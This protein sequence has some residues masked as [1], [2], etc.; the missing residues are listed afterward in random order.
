MDV[1]EPRQSLMPLAPARWQQNVTGVQL[2]SLGWGFC[3]PKKGRTCCPCPCRASPCLC[4]EDRWQA[5]R[6]GRSIAHVKTEVEN[7]PTL[8]GASQLQI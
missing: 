5:Q 8:F 3:G 4:I 1:E 7:T 6:R 2:F